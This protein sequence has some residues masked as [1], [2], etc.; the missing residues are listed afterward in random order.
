MTDYFVKN[1]GNDAASGL[2]DDNAWETLSQVSTGPGPGYNAGDSVFLKEDDEWREQLTVPSSGSN[3]S[4]ITFGAYGSGADPIIKGSD[5]VSTWESV[6][7]ANTGADFDGTNDSLSR[8]AAWTGAVD[9]KEGIFSCWIKIGTRQLSQIIA[10]GAFTVAVQQGVGGAIYFLA[11]GALD[12]NSSVLSTGTWHHILAS[13]DTANNEAHIYIDDIEDKTET[14]LNDA[15][16]DYDNA[17][18]R[19]GS[20]VNEAQKFDGAIQELYFNF[21]THL[22]LSVEANRRKFID[23]SG[24][25]VDLGADGSTPTGTA[26]HLYFKNVFGT[27]HTNLGSGGDCTVTGALADEGT[28]PGGVDSNVWQV[29]LASAPDAVYLDGTFGTKETSIAGLG[30][31]QEWYHTGAILYQHSTS[32]PDA[33]YASPGTE[34]SQRDYGITATSKDYITIN[35][36]DI[37]HAE[38]IG[39]D[40]TT[41]D[42]WT[43]Q[44]CN[45]QDYGDGDANAAGISFHGATGSEDN[46]DSIMIDT[47][48]IGTAHCSTDGSVER[49]GI[50]LHGIDNST[51]SNNTVTTGQTTTGTSGILIYLSHAG[52]LSTDNIIE[53]NDVTGCELAGIQT[54]DS[55]GTIIRYNQVHNHLG[56]GIAASYNATGTYCYYNLVYDIQGTSTQGNHYNGIDINQTS[57]NGFYY[58]NVVYDVDNFCLTVETSADGNTIKNN[59]LDASNNSNVQPHC[60]YV[61][62]SIAV[63]TFGNN[64]YYDS[65]D[66]DI[67]CWHGL[68][69]GDHKTFTEWIALTSEI[70]S[71]NSAHLMPDPANDN[72]KLAMNSPCID[73]GTHISYIGID[74]VSSTTGDLTVASP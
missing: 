48:T 31:D 20:L 10:S 12:L 1:G 19:I 15:T 63:V 23:A 65:G 42:D 16:L 41:V 71:I 43:I 57:V 45:V 21:V 36:L 50:R 53:N 47:N 73:V 60:V 17:A 13:W 3:G 66:A 14:T 11:S 35:G 52:S 26:P 69:A 72:F 59:I 6:Y 27:F 56:M 24:L 25:P 2:D 32:D 46:C 30:T 37:R 29:T 64:D 68:G 74:S 18:W 58:N 62:A 38:L 7:A 28:N 34:V 55:D 49:A 9:G 8:G 4:P 70:G 54:R 44:N 5:L 33:R 61:D 22:D 67:G 40:A 39:I 51:I